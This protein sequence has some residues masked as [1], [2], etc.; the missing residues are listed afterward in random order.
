MGSLLPDILSRKMNAD[1]VVLT[2]CQSG[3][4]KE[5]SGEVVLSMGRA[6]QFAEA[7]SVLMS[8]WEV[9]EIS[10]VTLAESLFRY[11]KEGKTKLE[12][13]KSTREDIRNAGCKHPFFGSAFIL[14]GEEG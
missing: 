10:A 8:L 2:A 6:F 9:E 7:K 14:V 11:R 3:L 13:L 4:S 1:V 5:L 12:S